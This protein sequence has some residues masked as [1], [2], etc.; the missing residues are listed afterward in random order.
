MH[1]KQYP[2]TA[3]NYN[4]ITELIQFTNVYF[5]CH[6]VR[7]KNSCEGFQLLKLPLEIGTTRWLCSR[8]A[9]CSWWSMSQYF[10]LLAKFSCNL[11]LMLSHH[12]RLY[13]RATA[14]PRQRACD[15]ETCDEFKCLGFVT[16]EICLCLYFPMKSNFYF[17]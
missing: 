8:V 1:N 11:L 13:A 9:L 16:E 12:Q 4:I 10:L 5:R 14:S 3:A 6:K 17:L 7:F 15:E 2:L